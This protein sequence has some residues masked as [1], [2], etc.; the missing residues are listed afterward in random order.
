MGSTSNL[1]GMGTPNNC[2]LYPS[3]LAFTCRLL[4]DSGTAG[5]ARTPDGKHLLPQTC[6]DSGAQRV[7]Q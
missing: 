1:P 3:S 4:D 5:L 6:C 7:R 2:P